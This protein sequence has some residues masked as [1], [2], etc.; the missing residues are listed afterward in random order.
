MTTLMVIY[1]LHLLVFIM[2]NGSSY[3]ETY[4]KLL[5]P[6]VKSISSKIKI[7]SSSHSLYLFLSFSQHLSSLIS[8]SSLSIYIIKVIHSHLYFYLNHIYSHLQHVISTNCSEGNYRILNLKLFIQNKI[9]HIYIIV[10]L[11]CYILLK[12]INKLF[13]F[14]YNQNYTNAIHLL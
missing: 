1:E 11:F 14:V 13:D 4:K 5:T 9:L 6:H 2:S 7:L 3:C 10:D 12:V 8:F